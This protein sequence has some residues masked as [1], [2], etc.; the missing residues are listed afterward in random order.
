MYKAME[1]IR[2]FEDMI[3]CLRQR[4]D[5]K[6]VAV[7]CPRD[8]STQAA[9]KMAEGVGFITPIVVDDD[10]PDR[11]CQAAVE[12]IRQGK[13]D[14]LMKGLVG[15]DKILRAILDKEHGILPQGHI[16]THITAAQVPT[17]PKMLFFG[18]CAVI[19][20][21]TEEQRIEQVRYITHVCHLIGIEEPRVSLLH[22]TEHADTRHFP[23]TACYEHIKQLAQQGE[24]GRCIVDG[25]LDLKTSCNPHAMH[26]KHISSPIEGQADALIMPDIEAGN[27]FYKTMDLFA[28]A[29]MA[30]ILQGPIVPVA[31]P[32]RGDDALSKYYG[33]AMAAV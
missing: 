13:A 20:Y 30:S 8:E 17:Y 4:G 33:L 26:I 10:D 21:P 9:L 25:P 27:I 7:V 12:L 23:F 14:I 11:A 5:K 6:R 15:S 29:T 2:K 16:L 28:H 31:M 32:S 24:F 19:P 22:C 18:D 1:N 3:S